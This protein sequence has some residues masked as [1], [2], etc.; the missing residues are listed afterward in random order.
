MIFY[1]TKILRSRIHEFG[2][3]ADEAVKRG[4]VVGIMSLGSELM[5][6]K[7]YQGGLRDKDFV[8]AQTGVRWIHK[9][10]MY[11]RRIMV[12][13]YINHSGRPNILYHC[14]MLLA[15][16]AIARGDELTCDYRL[17]LAKNDV[18][19]FAD[20]ES[21][22]WID[23]Y[24]AQTSLIVSSRQLIALVKD[25]GIPQTDREVERL[26][27]RL[28]SLPNVI[29]PDSLPHLSESRRPRVT[30]TKRRLSCF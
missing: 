2:V 5:S 8:C 4:A 24:D 11:D 12:E 25:A 14:G 7:S 29:E 16:K 27:Q 17:I 1:K 13:D 30:G 6:E 23:G 22:E 15:Q 20:S 3:F 19:A 9:F 26:M 28:K 18:D 10:F 21:S